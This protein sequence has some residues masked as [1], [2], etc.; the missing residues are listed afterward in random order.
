MEG[1]NKQ[2]K[3]LEKDISST[4]PKKYR[5]GFVETSLLKRKYRLINDTLPTQTSPE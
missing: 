4:A 5:Y 3:F 2:E 1:P